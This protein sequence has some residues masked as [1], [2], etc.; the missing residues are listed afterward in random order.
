[1]VN[2]GALVAVGN[3]DRTVFSQPMQNKTAETSL[4]AFR[5]IIGANDDIMPKEITAD[6]G[7]EWA[8]LEQE[9]AS[10]EFIS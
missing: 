1:M 3:Y 10:K 6:L 4:E 5:K 8:L 2:I 9:I 7:N